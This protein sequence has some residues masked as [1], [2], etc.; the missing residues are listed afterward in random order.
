M[1]RVHCFECGKK[2]GELPPYEDKSD[3]IDLCNDCSK[4]SKA[5]K[6]VVIQTKRVSTYL[7]EGRYET[8][9]AIV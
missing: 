9:V 5:R 4:E 7:L 1:P 2:M 8:E 3:I 6:Q